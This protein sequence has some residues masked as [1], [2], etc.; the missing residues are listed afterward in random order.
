MS[1]TS[2]FDHWIKN[3]AI[4]AA[5]SF[6]AVSQLSCLQD[7][8]PGQGC[9]QP[10]EVT[11]APES[12]QS[13]THIY[14]A[15][16]KL[17]L[18]ND[19]KVVVQDAYLDVSLKARAPKSEDLSLSLNGIKISR[20]DG[21]PVGE[22]VRADKISDAPKFRF[23]LHKMFLNGALP[24]HLFIARLKNNRGLLKL[25][26]L[27]PDVHVLDAR[28]V[29]NGAKAD[30]D[31]RNGDGA[32]DPDDN[33]PPGEKPAVV[34]ITAVSPSESLT[35]STTMQ[36]AFAAD[37]TGENFYCSLDGKSAQICQ[38]PKI[39]SGLTNGNHVFSVYSKSPKGLQSNSATHQW[40]VDSQPPTAVIDNAANLPALTNK[41]SI[42]FEFS[43]NEPGRLVCSLDGADPR[44][45]QS[46]LDLT[47]LAQGTHSFSVNVVDLAGNTGDQPARFDWTIDST[48]PNVNLVSV[49][50]P[51][52]V[53]NVSYKSFG[54]ATSESALTECAV[55]NGAFVPC[56]SPL[57][58]V[59]LAEGR[60][61]FEVRA[62]DL[63]GNQGPSATYAWN[64]DLSPPIIRMIG[65]NPPPGLSGANSL[66]VE[67][68]TSEEAV[69]TCRFDS[70]ELSPCSSPFS[71]AGI[72][73]GQHSLVLVAQD[74]AG[75]ESAL[76]EFTWTFDF[77]APQISFASLDP[78]THDIRSTNLTAVVQ[79]SDVSTL[80]AT[81]N[82]TALAQNSSPLT[83]TN[84]GE[85]H[86]VLAVEAEDPAGNRSNRITHEFNV[87][88]TA[89]VI[90]AFEP[91]DARSL[92]NADK[93]SFAF[94]ASEFSA[95]FQC[96]LDEAGFESCP[97]PMDIA[98]LADGAHTFSVRAVDPA[99]NIGPEVSDAWRID[100]RPPVVTIDAQQK[101]SFIQ[102][103]LS[104][105]ENEV[106][107]ECALDGADFATCI[108]PVSY[109][110]LNAG[111]HAFLARARDQAGNVLAAGTAHGFEVM[112]PVKTFLDNVS[113][114]GSLTNR[115]SLSVSFSSNVTDATFLCSLDGE[116]PVGCASPWAIES[117]GDGPHLLK[118]RA[119]D[120]H[121]N[122]DSVGVD[123]A[124]TIDATAPSVPSLSLNVTSTSITVT[125]NTNE[126]ATGQVIWGSGAN[127]DRVTPED[128]AKTTSHQTRLDGLSANTVYS[129]QV[130]GRDAAGNEYISTPRQIRTSR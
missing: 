122:T 53:N 105:D 81:L 56:T 25:S 65:V 104:A 121:G 61:W 99:G 115:R 67:F 55:D 46:P 106:S 17:D 125:W 66:R 60:H 102:F 103:V 6:L 5:L 85:G 83:L 33:D 42:S 117:L 38:S 15:P 110:G 30:R 78:A 59:S 41:N 76:T 50:P 127:L 20:R 18:F 69:V 45:C 27:G 89:P 23:A 74:V 75:N 70:E 82:G 128:S 29:I 39:Y 34:R 114:A 10:F 31:D 79:G 124:W 19:P 72:R 62:T 47:G 97:S 48:P 54:F 32:C 28:M 57:D 58:L 86:Y 96:Q 51:T 49:A 52:N 26:V 16:E 116:A 14:V 8:G 90:T 73:E 98:G 9:H 107:Y 71:R 37:R 63:A 12:I 108:S 126:P 2:K 44:D 95:T 87:D 91:S 94:T 118:I 7:P 123:H 92:V 77:T 24:F 113:P 3:L 112:V 21:R 22:N 84:L 36:I 13:H 1:K 111:P 88:L 100:T 11:I 68:A 40:M 101:D 109:S 119:T 4:G 35:N 80:H 43:A 93:R 130:V 120:R 129:V 64:V